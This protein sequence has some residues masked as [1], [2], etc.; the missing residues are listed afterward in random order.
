[1]VKDL[2]Q[3]ERRVSPGVGVGFEMLFGT[4]EFL[5]RPVTF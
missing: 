5:A 4:D 3:Q 1:M 2:P